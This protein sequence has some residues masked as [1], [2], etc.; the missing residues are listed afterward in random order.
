LTTCNLPTPQYPLKDEIKQICKD[1][2]RMEQNRQIGCLESLDCR[3]FLSDI[4]FDLKKSRSSAAQAADKVAEY[5]DGFLMGLTGSRR[6]DIDRI[7]LIAD[8]TRLSHNIHEIY[9][10]QRQKLGKV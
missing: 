10:L 1:I 5:R 9:V 4:R 6:H 3:G 8:L 2:N 7:C